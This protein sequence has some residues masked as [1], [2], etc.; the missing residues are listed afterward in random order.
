MRHGPFPLFKCCGVLCSEATKVG[1]KRIYLFTD[2]GSNFNDNQLD[3]ICEGVRNL[4][5]HL[6]I[7]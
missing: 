7:V 6:T 3:Q 2:G 5:V 4:D 1:E